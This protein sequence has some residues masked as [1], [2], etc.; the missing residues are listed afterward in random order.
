MDSLKL[1]IRTRGRLF[2]WCINA[3]ILF[4]F[5][6]KILLLECSNNDTFW[7]KITSEGP[8]T[9]T[10][11]LQNLQKKFR[12]RKG[13]ERYVRGRDDMS[14]GG[15]IC[16]GTERKVRGKNGTRDGTRQNKGRNGTE[17][18]ALKSRCG[19]CIL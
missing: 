17:R 2:N 3:Y 18:K 11:G 7:P 13:K 12:E 6:W 1:I 5:F 4:S 14:R 15:T 10:S 8:Y 16:P 19:L 9:D